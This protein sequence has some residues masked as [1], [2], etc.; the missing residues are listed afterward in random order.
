MKQERTWFSLSEIHS[1][2]DF[3]KVDTI[4]LQSFQNLA[5][6]NCHQSRVTRVY[7]SLLTSDLILL[8][9][10]NWINLQLIETFSD[11]INNKSS[12]S[13][14][15][16]LLTLITA[17]EQGDLLEKIE[18]HEKDKK[19]CFIIIVNAGQDRDLNN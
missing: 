9:G 6:E 2:A 14:N 12:N 5:N 17:I 16:S 8:I 18:G 13:I 10:Q 19:D 15:I 4:I 11:F 3:P 1:P 7:P